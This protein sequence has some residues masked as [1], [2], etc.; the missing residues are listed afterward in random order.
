M[1]NAMNQDNKNEQKWNAAKGSAERATSDV[2][3]ALKSIDTDDLRE[4]A[5]EIT[6]KVRDVS[7][8]LYNETVGF[9]KRYPV[10][11]ALGLAAVGYFLGAISRRSK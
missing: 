5:S 2:K 8:G 7:S 9:V 6:A 1:Q 3:S 4:A 10:S 11:S